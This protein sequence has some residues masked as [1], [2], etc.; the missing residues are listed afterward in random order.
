MVLHYAAWEGHEDAVRLLLSKAAEIDARSNRNGRTALHFAT[1]RANEGV[2]ELLLER[3]ADVNLADCDRHTVLMLWVL[4]NYRDISW[5]RNQALLLLLLRND[6]EL[7][8][9]E[10]DRGWTALHLTVTM[11]RKEM[12]ALLLESGASAS[13]LCHSW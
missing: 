4:K 6:A 2:V 8:A 12:V 11:R 9:V 10:H 1:I 3:G 7:D 13:V 5:E